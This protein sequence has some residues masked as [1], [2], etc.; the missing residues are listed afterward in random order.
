MVLSYRMGL[1]P[2][3]YKLFYNKNKHKLVFIITQHAVRVSIA[4]GYTL[5]TYKERYLAR[6][7]IKAS[8][9]QSRIILPSYGGMQEDMVLMK[10]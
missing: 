3:R 6:S 4:V 7:L 9:V 8:E 10:S 5:T 1:A 2:A